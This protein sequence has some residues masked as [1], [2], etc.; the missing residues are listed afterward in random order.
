ME[1]TLHRRVLFICLWSQAGYLAGI[2][3]HG[4]D[5]AGAEAYR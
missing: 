5:N 1:G 3:I 4:R 2:P